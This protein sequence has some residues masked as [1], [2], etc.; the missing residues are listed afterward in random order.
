MPYKDPEKRR[1]AARRHQQAYRER[2]KVVP[3]GICSKYPSC[4][5]RTVAPFKL[6]PDCREYLQKYKA[7]YRKKEAPPGICSRYPDCANE[8]GAFRICRRCLD[9]GSASQKRGRPR[10]RRRAQEVKAEVIGHYGGKCVCCAVSILEMLNIDHIDLYSGEG[11]RAGDKLYRWLKRNG[12]P[13]GF[14]VLCYNCNFC[15]AMRGYCPHGSMTQKKA[16]TR[17][18]N[19]PPISPEKREWNRQYHLRIKQAAMEA[20]GGVACSCCDESHLEHLTL[21]HIDGR[22]ADHRREDPSAIN[23]SLWV[24]KHNY[25]TGFRVLCSNCNVSASRSPDQLCFHQRRRTFAPA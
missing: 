17:P 4:K 24:R 15:L 13:E 16:A 6:C 23:L 8:V 19:G 25:P 10:L 2:N 20:Y 5:K 1:A 9:S 22:G 18:T 11:P 7:K 14:R 3:P 21:D 12:Y